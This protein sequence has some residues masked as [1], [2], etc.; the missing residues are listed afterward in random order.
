MLRLAAVNAAGPL[1]VDVLCGGV[2]P[3]DAESR[4]AGQ[5]S[6]LHALTQYMTHYHGERNHQGL[7]NRVLQPLDIGEPY[8]AVRRRQRL[9]GMLSYY[10]RQAA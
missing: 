1:A 10:R 6:L 2:G 8:G 9:G 5:A 7:G 3:Q 4:T